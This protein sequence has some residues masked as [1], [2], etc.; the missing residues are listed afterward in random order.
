[1]TTECNQEPFPF[2]PLNQREVRG[3]FDGGAITSDAGGLLLREVEKRTNIIG[4]FASCFSDYRD[5]EL[6]EHGVA[7]LV[8]QRIYGLALGYEDLNDHEE[9]RRD[10]L[11][12]VLV[13]KEDLSGEERR[14]VRDQGTARAG[15]STLN[16]MELGAAKLGEKERYKKII[17][18]EAAVDRTLVD[19]FLQAQGE[20]RK[21]IVLDLDSTDIAL[22][23]E[24]E[25]RFFHGYYGHYCYLPLYIVCGEHVLCARLRPSNIDGAQGSVAEVERIVAQIRQ[26]WPQVRII[27]RGDSGF[28]RDEL[29]SWCE[30]HGVDYVVGL[31]QNARLLRE[32]ATA[33]A[34]AASQ[35][36]Q[37][38]T[39]A[40]V[41]S[42]FVYR[43]KKSWSRARR[44]IAKAE[45]LEKGA[46]PRFVVTWLSPE[47]T[48]FP[49]PPRWGAQSLYEELYCARG[50]ME[51]RIKRADDVVCRPHQHVL[52]AEQSNPAL[53]LHRGLPA[54]AGSPAV[55]V[56]GYRTGPR[57]MQHRALEVA[58]DRGPDSH[59]GT[60]NLG[61]AVDRLSVPGAVP[62]GAPAVT[63]HRSALLRG[64]E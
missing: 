54:D 38:G 32:I 45:H 26:A 30:E 21:E 16:R 39:A 22:Q 28:C 33:S 20:A 37:S 8:A 3:Q 10:P 58:Q 64:R 4:Q 12:A 7:E 48:I 42:E 44:V 52:A 40:R 61:V 23:G 36:Q 49:A 6:V 2:H 27:L 62:P 17:L 11:L 34:Q 13:E 35:Y 47:E 25:E 1:M 24:Q 51:N 63:S 57:A 56:G 5:P 60:Q 53:L 19:I 55:R 46:N 18:D 29:L 14:R 9:L 41:F 15:K 59:H 43:T 31:A 50:E